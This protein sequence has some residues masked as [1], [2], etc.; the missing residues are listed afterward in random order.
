M[1]ATHFEATF[2]KPEPSFSIVLM[3]SSL[4]ELAATVEEEIERQ[5]RYESVHSALAP[6]ARVCD[7]CFGAGTG[8]GYAKRPGPRGPRILRTRTCPEC[9]GR[10]DPADYTGAVQAIRFN[11]GSRHVWPDPFAPVRERIRQK[12]DVEKARRAV[13]TERYEQA[14]ERGV[15]AFFAWSWATGDPALPRDL[16][17]LVA[18]L[19]P[20]QGE[21]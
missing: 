2:C 1:G 11:R 4:E 3:G 21:E 18:S 14:R 12:L 10:G 13:Y 5:R 15:P 8:P 20:K 7:S 6:V 16:D 19:A 9:R 17:D